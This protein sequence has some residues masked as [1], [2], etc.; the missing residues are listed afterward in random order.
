V[1]D[2]I[3]YLTF[4]TLL[5][6]LAS[7]SS[8]MRPLLH[9]NWDDDI[10]FP[11]PDPDFSKYRDQV[12]TYLNGYSLS[13]RT[14]S[15][16]DLN[17]PF[18]FAANT[19]VPYRGKFLLIHGLS[20][21]TYVWRDMAQ[22]MVKN[23]FDVRAILLP[24]HGSHPVNMLEVTHNEWLLAARQH[25]KNWNVDD[26]PVYLG[27]F[28]MGA[29]IATI[30]ALENPDIAGLL[31]VSPAF[32]S[33]LN[34]ILRWAW[35]YKWFKPWVFNGMILEDNPTKYNSIP[36]NSGAQYYNVTE[37]LKDHWDD[38]IL[39]MPALMISTMDD[40]VVDVNYNR[41]I[42]QQHFVSDK[43][44]F[45]IYSNDPED[46]LN[47]YEIIRSS[48]R[49]DLRILN[50][51]HLSL[52]NSPGN[53][54]YGENGSLLVCN[55]NDYPTFSACMRAKS[56]WWGAQHTASPDGIPVARTTYNPDFSSIVEL[57]DE[58]FMVEQ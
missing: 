58:V 32:H 6:F 7:C 24:G 16:I 57:F 5:F 10:S 53:H 41:V 14:E 50:Q 43:R 8:Q 37:Y 31:L 36:V 44:K 15:Q 49:P 45:L 26:T 9:K 21:S 54:L 46:K 51:S 40:S 42:F 12:K 55:G 48:S 52:I 13:I 17:M 28:S 4:L 23:G 30:L 33:Q 47:T 1:S 3:K 18:E 11:L 34:S 20:D 38:K 35:I 39:A 19:S 25:F 2:L 56:H 29:V 27:G 22:N